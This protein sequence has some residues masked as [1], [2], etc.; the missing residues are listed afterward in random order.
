MSPKNIIC[1]GEVLWDMLPTG[2]MPGGAPMNVAFH[3]KN[4]GLNTALISRVGSDDLGDE[5]I[6]FM[7]KAGLDVSLVQRGT[8]HLTGVVKVNMDDANEVTYKIVQPVAWDYIQLEEEA[9]RAVERSDGFV[10]GSLA[11]RNPGTRETLHR[12]LEKATF[13]I[14][15]VNFREPYYT[16]ETVEYLL[17]QADMVKMN[18]HE[19]ALITAW[20][21]TLTDERSAIQRLSERFDVPTICV[22]RGGSGAI[23]W[24]DGAF[25]ESRGFA[26][27]VSDTI[28]S[29]DSFLAAL[30]KGLLHNDPPAESLEFACATGSL[31]A[32]RQG[33]TPRIT[34]D[35]I[36]SLMGGSRR[37]SQ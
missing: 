25:Y 1:F 26:V 9:V 27:Q 11:A 30:I 31:V 36:R 21:G 6:E 14:F 35:E 16:Q 17:Q 5:L 33:A 24:K 15:D 28:G 12:L 29:G 3:L 4:F 8:N 13:K 32:S 34:G 10:F 18:A 37:V 19:L 20:Q 7:Q 23:L 2:K 22:T